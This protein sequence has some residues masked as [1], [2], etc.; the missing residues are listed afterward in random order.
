MRRE[1]F[2]SNAIIWQSGT[3]YEISIC[4]K[5]P[6]NNNPKMTIQFKLLFYR[7]LFRPVYFLFFQQELTRILLI[8]YFGHPPIVH[9]SSKQ[10]DVIF[11][12]LKCIFLYFLYV[13]TLF[14]MVFLQIFIFKRIL[15]RQ[16]LYLTYSQL[17]TQWLSLRETEMVLS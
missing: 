5:M 17:D 7:S 15:D 12:H 4:E 10:I 1:N 13:F 8:L 14:Q 16:W 11:D 6:K 9:S 2:M 3:W